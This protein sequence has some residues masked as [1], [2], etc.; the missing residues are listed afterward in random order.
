MEAIDEA[1]FETLA[2]GIFQTLEEQ[3]DRIVA[4]RKD[5]PSFSL[6]DHLEPE[7]S[8]EL[9]HSFDDQDLSET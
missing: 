8:S 9:S 6:R 5:V 1:K 7:S 4:A 3:Y 2:H